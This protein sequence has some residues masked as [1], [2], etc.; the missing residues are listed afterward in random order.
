MVGGK[1]A[2]LVLLAL[3]AAAACAQTAPANLPPRPILS[4]DLLSVSVYGAQE[5]TRSVRVSGDGSIR[6]PMLSHPVQVKGLLPPEVESRI[7]AALVADEIL[8]DPAVSVAITEYYSKPV[9]VAGAVRHPLTFPVYQSIT[10]LEALTRAE[11][12]SADAG[13]EILVTRP[14]ESGKPLVERIPVKALMDGS[15]PELNLTLEGGEEVRVPELGRVFVAGNVRRSGAFRIEDDAGMTVLKAIALAEGLAPYSGKEAYI[16]RRSDRDPQ[17]APAEI[18]VALREIT[19]RKSPDV[20]LLANDIL[21]IPD[22]RGA[23]VTANAIEK[24]IAFAAGTASGA[25]ILG[26]NR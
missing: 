1:T 18:P 9:S 5:L 12:L 20:A 25:L 6:L 8:V 11:G 26:V 23:R 22:S 24:I 4:G 2:S 16:L 14:A 13:S 10:L 15:K 7:A 17:A 3:F 19:D 21:Y